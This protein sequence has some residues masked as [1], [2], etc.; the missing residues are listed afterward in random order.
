[1][2]L[3]QAVNKQDPRVKRTRRLLQDTF[4]ELL[5]EKSFDAITVQ[6]IADRSTIN[7]ATF[8]A[9]Y[10]DKYDLF[11]QFAR[12]SFRKDLAH[13]VPAEGPLTR[14]NVRSLALAIMH[15]LAALNDHCRPTEALKPLVMSTVQEEV[16]A[17]L[18]SWS[19]KRDDAATEASLA[20]ASWAIFGAALKW[21]QSDPRPPADETAGHIAAFTTAGL[22]GR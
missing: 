17:V 7:R 21:S 4:V 16:A 10:T 3:K 1:M 6:D 11:G 8:Y 19:Q 18:L 14:E 15:A 13:S 5:R 9:H 2:A 20:S 22:A 12:E